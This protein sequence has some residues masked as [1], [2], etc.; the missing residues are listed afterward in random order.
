MGFYPVCPGIDQY[1]LGAPLFKK[2]T[3][4]FENGK[5]LLINAP[6]NSEANLYVQSVR[7]NG[8]VNTKNWVNHFDLLKG[9]TLNFLMG[10][11]PNK[12]RGITESDYPYSF[13]KE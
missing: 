1:V 4:Q 11:S 6:A 8:K 7:L 2:M 5:Q 13:S 9:G 12:Q 3:I 10:A